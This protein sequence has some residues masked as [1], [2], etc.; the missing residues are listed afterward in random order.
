MTEEFN[1]SKRVKEASD[2][3]IEEPHMAKAGFKGYPAIYLEEDV[4]E[5]IRRLKEMIGR[6][7][8]SVENVRLYYEL[9]KLAGDKLK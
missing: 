5:F 7:H 9:D 3:E 4:K 6:L 1:L 2:S 8:E